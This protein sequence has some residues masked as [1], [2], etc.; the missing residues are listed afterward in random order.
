MAKTVPSGSW[1][2]T[3]DPSRIPH[4]RRSA[5]LNNESEYYTVDDLIFTIG[6]GEGNAGILGELINVTNPDGA[7]THLPSQI[8]AG[9]NLEDILR[10]MLHTYI[11]TTCG[12]TSRNLRYYSGTSW[13]GYEV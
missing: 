5:K 4:E 7:F 10:D 12:L 8:A 13:G 9:T 2:H 3:L 1:F 6:G 11:V